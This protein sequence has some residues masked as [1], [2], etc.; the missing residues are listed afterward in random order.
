MHKR[1]AALGIILALA[2]MVAV[3][4][5]AEAGQVKLDGTTHPTGATTE[6]T[7]VLDG[8]DDHADYTIESDIGTVS[9]YDD[10]D[11]D[12]TDYFSSFFSFE[13]FDVTTTTSGDTYIDVI[14]ISVET[15]SDVS[16]AAYVRVTDSDASTISGYVGSDTDTMVLMNPKGFN[17]NQPNE[18]FDT[19]GQ[20]Y[21]QGYSY[22]TTA[23]YVEMGP[24]SYG[25]SQS[26]SGIFYA[27]PSQSSDLSFANPTAVGFTD[28]L[29]APMTF[30][31]AR[32]IWQEGYFSVI[33][34]PLQFNQSEIGFAGVLEI[35]SV[36]SAGEVTLGEFGDE[37]LGP[38]DIGFDI[39][40]GSTLTGFSHLGDI[41]FTGTQGTA[42]NI[43]YGSPETVNNVLYN[44][45]GTLYIQGN[46]LTITDSYG[47]INGVIGEDY[48][49][50]V[51]IAKVT[52]ELTISGGGQIQN[53]GLVMIDATSNILIDGYDA[54]AGLYSGIYSAGSGDI[55]VMLQ[56]DETLTVS[57]LARINL[58]E[59]SNLAVEATTV[60]LDDA[61]VTLENTGGADGGI[62]SFDVSDNMTLRDGSTIFA[63]VANGDEED[64]GST[65]DI[66]LD[67]DGDLSMEAGAQIYQATSTNG[68]TTGA[69]NITADGTATL[70]G[71]NP[72]AQDTKTGILTTSTSCDGSVGDIN[73]TAGAL[74]MSNEAIITATSIGE[75]A[76]VTVGQI[77]IDV[78]GA[79]TLSTSGTKITT[80]VGDNGTSQ[81][82]AFNAGSLTADYAD[83]AA[84]ATGGG[85]LEVLD[86]E[87]T[88]TAAFTNNADITI[89]V[90][91]G[92]SAGISLEAATYTSNN[93]DIVITT[94]GDGD[95]GK[96]DVVVS[97][98]ATLE[99]LTDIKVKIESTGDSDGIE[100]A[101]GTLTMNNSDIEIETYIEND[102]DDRGDAGLIDITVTG[103]ASLTNGSDI[104]SFARN[105]NSAGISLTAGSFTLDDSDISLTSSGE[106][107]E[108]TI[109]AVTINVTGAAAVSND[110][111]IESS[112]VKGDSQG[113]D[114]DAGSLS[115]TGSNMA[116]SSTGEGTAGLTDITATGAVTLNEGSSI[117]STV[118]GT[119]ASMGITVESASL[120]M[121]NSAQIYTSTTGATIDEEDETAAGAGGN[122][123]I[124]T[125]G[126]VTMEGTEPPVGPDM[127]GPLVADPNPE[128][129]TETS[130][131]G[132]CGN[133]TVTADGVS[134]TNALIYTSTSS[135]DE[136]AA[137]SGDITITATDAVTLMTS[138]GVAP[139]GVIPANGVEVT[140]IFTAAYGAGDAG[141]ILITATDIELLDG[142]RVLS[143]TSSTGATGE[144]TLNGSNTIRFDLDTGYDWTFDG[145]AT[146][147]GE[148]IKEGTG[149]LTLEGANTYGDDTTVS[150]GELHLAQGAAIPDASATTLATG[151][152]LELVNAS[153]TIGSLA[154]AGDVVLNSYTLTA[155]GNDN[156][157]LYTGVISGTG[158]FTK[159]G[160]GTMTMTGES[161]YTGA[162]TLDEGMIK[163]NGGGTVL[164]DVTSV[165]T[166]AGTTLEL[167]DADETIGSLAG[168]GNVTL[169]EHTLTAGGDDTS[170]VYSGVIA[171]TG[172]FIKEG[173][174]EMT[175]SGTNT[176]T[177]DCDINDG[178][179]TLDSAT[180]IE[181]S[182]AV[183]VALGAKMDLN[184]LDETIGSL[185]GAGDVDLGPGSLT[186]GDNHDTTTDS[187][188]MWGTG[189]LVKE[190]TGTLTL[191][192]INSFSGDT[193]LNE[194]MIKL[195]NGAGLSTTTA[196]TAAAGTTVELTNANETAGSLAGA[197][198]VV[199]GANT[200]TVGSNDT[201]TTY[202]G[203]IP[204]TGGL[205]K[206]GTGTMTLE[207]V[208]T[209]TGATTI[210][211]GGTLKL[212]AAG[213]AIHDSSAV[214]AN[215]TLDLNN[216]D[217]T[218]GSL[219]GA[220]SVTMG[221]GTLTTGGNDTSTVFSGAISGT[222]DVGL[223]KEG[224]GTLTLSGTNTFTGDI[225]LNVGSLKLAG[226]SAIE[227]TV[228]VTALSGTVLD[229][230]G[231]T[232]TIGSLS[233]AG[234]VTLGA[235][236]LTAGFNN[237]TTT[238]SGVIAGTGAFV[239]TGTGTMTL[240]GSSTL[241]G[242]TYVTGGTLALGDGTL[243]GNLADS[244]TYVQAA[245]IL[246]GT[247][248]MNDLFVQNGGTVAP[249]LAADPVI[250]TITVN[251]E[252]Y[253][254]AGALYE[255]EIG[256]NLSNE[257]ETDLIDVTG[258]VTII[259]GALLT[260]KPVDVNGN[261]D[262]DLIV[263]SSLKYPLIDFGGTRTGSY[264]LIGITDELELYTAT[265]GYETDGVYYM[266]L[267]D[268]TAF[269]ETAEIN[270]PLSGNQGAVAERFDEITDD[271]PDMG[272]EQDEA[273]HDLG[274]IIDTVSLL[275][276]DAQQKAAVDSLSGEFHGN[277]ASVTFNQDNHYHQVITGHLG[278]S[279]AI[280]NQGVGGAGGDEAVAKPS[281][282]SGWAELQRTK[283]ENDA[284]QFAAGFEFDT[285]TLAFGYEKMNRAGNTYGIGG[286]ISKTNVDGVGRR[287]YS[288]IETTHL[289]LYG[290]WERG[291]QHNIAIATYATS[292]NDTA[293]PIIIGAQTRLAKG[294]F[295]SET[296]S[297]YLEHGFKKSRKRNWDLQPILSARYSKFERDRFTETNAGAAG[298]QV[299]PVEYSKLEGAFGFKLTR[300][301]SVKRMRTLYAKY[302]YD[303][304][305]DDL[306]FKAYFPARPEDFFQS[307]GIDQDRD[308]IE[309]GFGL[310][311][312]TNKGNSSFT[313]MVN[314]IHSDSSQSY[315]IRAN[316]TFRW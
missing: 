137:D 90:V 130:D 241:T 273:K 263:D 218:I 176:F 166:A 68:G 147:D 230:N 105:N 303:F 292:E 57:N 9:E 63:T 3:T 67:V 165:V 27:D 202:S 13:H 131:D 182:V 223:I 198:N 290:R 264:S 207:G 52:E 110:S 80:T 116:V 122:I 255:A 44:A 178:T 309:A 54:V 139:G 168:A 243:T 48:G 33:G 59:G 10:P 287:D 162:T 106:T 192:G 132:D 256:F 128:I 194:G 151:T 96:I 296:T 288:D 289:S 260:I 277:L 129:F 261:P 56:T 271:Y 257:I 47:L 109:G 203:V 160:T 101:A 61:Y 78:T 311:T 297:L 115:I 274:W 158:G 144:V 305:D 114:F 157:T 313:V 22:L 62:I 117:R 275:P 124:I 210:D 112:V 72:I 55:G 206:T 14:G 250:G 103:A 299:E 280:L 145:V 199:L 286:G 258:D 111:L 254:N 21:H 150:A 315:G 227:D 81:G 2:V 172:G 152:T 245:A 236:Q 26:D 304:T 49:D 240:T 39:Y 30:N 190:G 108:T 25:D 314:G 300:Q 282:A 40:E 238:Y 285:T 197:G 174:G 43:V 66:T 284:D 100:I 201:S 85:T 37:L 65:G 283:G 60:M 169:N 120:D 228:A 188:D 107:V 183:T 217:E 134:M 83:I 4:A 301:T 220:G 154:G 74:V 252:Y 276:D 249:G 211:A 92:T 142:S 181:D 146:G 208:N 51:M 34:G 143:T 177:G 133:I 266:L 171:G 42:Y 272:I 291:D 265:V 148:L 71:Y 159:V 98:D 102:E 224:T 70:T 307:T 53:T 213:E 251:G 248:Q 91:N 123:T 259:D 19:A 17:F 104:N 24:M 89:D 237:D 232:E 233:G 93:S 118:T 173:D 82:I 246:A 298:L 204:G 253:Q 136:S 153:E 86:F 127:A 267:R 11:V 294:A 29:I 308:Y 64:Q 88:G 195:A 186:A 41:E 226:G 35:I 269:E 126:D 242:S 306:V 6:L 69:I 164:S 180:A 8:V 141:D 87:I 191:S 97:G 234:N 244:D 156:T 77:D 221:T 316:Y 7:P 302:V 196:L 163:L 73:L 79:A 247:G 121:N 45:G 185:A 279:G 281:R 214:T 75:T 205:T 23:D 293:R 295:D 125:T 20:L 262:P 215:G 155:G 189:G 140:Q 268:E 36:A 270:L 209:Y 193:D 32:P 94:A 138:G 312:F 278:G 239:K 50:S 179:L 175:I 222:A 46:N 95:V 58:T 15:D 219:A 161:T 99:A 16:T 135:A 28:N 113:I 84:T 12:D 119:G 31:N 149:T 184:D 225:Q 235:G 310:T 76:E 216:L 167:V 170:T 1:T 229:V 5:P 212:D 200:F 187:G 38:T 231:S 18:A